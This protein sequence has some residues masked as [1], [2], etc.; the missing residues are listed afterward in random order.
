VNT[1]WQVTRNCCTSGQCVE[2]HQR[3]TPRPARIVHAANVTKAY[4]DQCV[5]G[6]AAYKAVAAPMADAK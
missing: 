3:G 5:V 4:A 6:W 1:N 2:C